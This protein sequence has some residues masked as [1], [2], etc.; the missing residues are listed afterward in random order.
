VGEV[1]PRVTAVAVVLAH[2]TPLA[3]A[4][5]RTPLLPRNLL[6]VCGFESV[7]EVNALR[8]QAHSPLAEVWLHGT[9]LYAFM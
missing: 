9:L 3:L 2:R 5:V 7:L 4:Q 6:H 8:A 1:I